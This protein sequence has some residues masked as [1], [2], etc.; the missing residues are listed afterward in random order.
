MNWFKCLFR[1]KPKPV[2]FQLAELGPDIIGRQG[3]QKRNRVH[4]YRQPFGYPIRACDWIAV[5]EEDLEDRRRP[6]DG[7]LWADALT[8]KHCLDVAQGK[9]EVNHGHGGGGED[10]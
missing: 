3:G 8:C 9:R 6:V 1:R 5:E 10:N 7:E 2:P 4:L